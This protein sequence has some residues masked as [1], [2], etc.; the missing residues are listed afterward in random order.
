MIKFADAHGNRAPGRE[1]GIGEAS[2]RDW[3]ELDPQIIVHSFKKCCISNALDGSEDNI[4]R[5][6]QAIPRARRYQRL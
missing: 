4:L 6:D 2:I 5:E 3:Q 1:F